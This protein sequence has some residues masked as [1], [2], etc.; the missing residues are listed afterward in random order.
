MT[1]NGEVSR[2]HPPRSSRRD[3]RWQGKSLMAL[4]TVYVFS[5][6]AGT[7]IRTATT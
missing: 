7:C 1:A 3:Y 5:R 2:P 6:L 4:D